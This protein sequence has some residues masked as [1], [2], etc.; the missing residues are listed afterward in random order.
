[1]GQ[2]I[3]VNSKLWLNVYYIIISMFKYN[4]VVIE[5]NLKVSIYVNFSLLIKLKIN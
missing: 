1:M 4:V 5:L 2:F 3:Y